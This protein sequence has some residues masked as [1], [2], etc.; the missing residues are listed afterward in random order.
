MARLKIAVI[1]AGSF[2]FGPS[3]VL[4]TIVE[5]RLQNVELALVDVDAD[6]IRSFSNT[7]QDTKSQNLAASLASATLCA[8]L[9]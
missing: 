7:F 9:Q 5:H 1:G 8:K 6:I 2:V 3:I 4:Q